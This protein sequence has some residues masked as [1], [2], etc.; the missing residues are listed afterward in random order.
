MTAEARDKT[1]GNLLG[2]TDFEAM[3]TATSII[4]AII[5][6]LDDEA[7]AYQALDKPRRRPRDLHVEHVIACITELAAK[8]KRPD[9]FGGLYFFNP[10]PLMKLVE[11]V[12][13]LTTS[14]ATTARSW[15]SHGRSAKSPSPPHKPGFSEPPAG[16]VSPR[17]HPLLRARP[18]HNRGHRQ[19]DEARLRISDGTADAPSILWA[20]TRLLHR[21][22]SCSMD[23]RNRCSRRRRSSSAWSWRTRPEVRRGFYKYA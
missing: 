11:V 2:V 20:S 9:R 22:T 3:G 10:V 17:R 21:E 6:N 12:R 4:E 5:E 19:R 15:S 14:D 16:A 1:W 7:A 23:T 18:R 13:G 8:T